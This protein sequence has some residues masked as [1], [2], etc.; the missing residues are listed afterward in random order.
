MHKHEARNRKPDPPGIPRHA[1]QHDMEFDLLRQHDDSFGP[2]WH[3]RTNHSTV[4]GVL[5]L[6][7][8]IGN[9][10]TRRLLTHW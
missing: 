4:P 2:T 3:S 7:S 5:R 10:A 1:A 8:K 6:Q 9:Q